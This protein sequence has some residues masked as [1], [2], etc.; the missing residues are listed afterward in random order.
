IYPNE[1]VGKFQEGEAITANGEF[2]G[3][4]IG[5]DGEGLLNFVFPGHSNANNLKGIQ[6][7]GSSSG[8]KTVFPEDFRAGSGYGYETPGTKTLRIWDDPDSQ[9]IRT[10]LSH[11]DYF[12][13]SPSNR[14]YSSTRVYQRR[15]M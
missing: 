5:I 11:T 1:V 7:S 10:S 2:L 8:A 13:A 15:D 12:L 4:Y 6:L 3:E 14:D 9:G